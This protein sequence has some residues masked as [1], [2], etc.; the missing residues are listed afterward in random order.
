MCEKRF[1]P[2]FEP[3]SRQDGRTDDHIFAYI[4]VNL[5]CIGSQVVDVDRVS[6]RVEDDPFLALFSRANAPD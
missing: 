3:G 1:T 4:Q 2:E 5:T 6:P